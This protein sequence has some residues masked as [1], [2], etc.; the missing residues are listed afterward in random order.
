MVNA[1]RALIIKLHEEKLY[2]V[3]PYVASNFFEFPLLFPDLSP[4]SP[5]QLNIEKLRHVHFNMMI[6]LNNH[7]CAC[8]YMFQIANICE[9]WEI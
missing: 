4:F 9:K 2:P 5:D 8:L 1:A 7:L 6:Y 3:S